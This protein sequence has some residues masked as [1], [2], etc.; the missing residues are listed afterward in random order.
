MST[1]KLVSVLIALILT[2]QSLTLAFAEPTARELAQDELNQWII[3]ASSLQVG[4]LTHMNTRINDQRTAKARLASQRWNINNADELKRHI[5]LLY[6]R[7]NHYTF[8][9][10]VRLINEADAQICCCRVQFVSSLYERMGESGIIAYDYLRVAELVRLGYVSGWLTLDEAHYYIEPVVALL[11]LSFSSWEQVMSNYLDGRYYAFDDFLADGPCFYLDLDFEKSKTFIQAHPDIFDD[12]LFTAP[13]I[14][15]RQHTVSAE[16]DDITGYWCFAYKNHLETNVRWFMF[17]G[18]DGTVVWYVTANSEATQF[19]FY[20]GTYA[21]H[22][23]IYTLAF[24]DYINKAG[25]DIL[26]TGFASGAM[27]V[28]LSFCTNGETLY[29]VQHGMGDIPAFVR[30]DGALVD[31]ILQQRVIP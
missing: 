26:L 27:Q 9:N 11:Q 20:Q 31:I 15:N 5:D 12:G 17:F 19:M 1:K 21:Y 18:N 25:R 10:E 8:M 13:I 2:A 6:F 14:A 29:M 16:P 24:D 28:R 7:G 23:G 4:S 22:D 30:A 3:A